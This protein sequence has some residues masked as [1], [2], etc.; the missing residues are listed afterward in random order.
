VASLDPLIVR[1]V[2]ATDDDAATAY[3]SSLVE[4]HVRPLVRTIAQR[5]LRSFTAPVQAADEVEDAVGEAVVLL[6]ERLQA[7]RGAQADPI[8]SLPDY[9]AAVAP[10]VC[11]HRVRRRHPERARLKHR[12]RYVFDTHTTLGLWR[13]SGGDAICGL[14]TWAG[15]DVDTVA[16]ERLH[17][18]G[19][20]DASRLA[21][22][23]R[24]NPAT[25]GAFAELLL[26]EL[27]G[28]IAFDDL[29]GEVARANRLDGQG[30]RDVTA[31]TVSVGPAIG[32]AAIDRRRLTERLWKEVQ[33]L[34]VRQRTALLL[35]LREP[36][37]Q[38]ALW[39]LPALGIATIRDIARVI[40][41]PPLELAALWKDLPLDDLQI[42]GRLG[43]TRQQVI[44]LRMSAR[45]RLTTRLA[46][47]EKP[48]DRANLRTVS[49]SPKGD[50]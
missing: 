46:A 21:L 28:A 3:L 45:K 43:C 36:G 15:A 37:G 35:N 50:S 5:K 41:I 24:D 31:E 14:R 12:L 42:A 26:G 47:A 25:L 7:I 39:V 19:A 1:F 9:V 38:G 48:L 32:E 10:H 30:A 27:G 11:A 16:T 20:S 44:N 34:P 33:E 17:A 23:A 22:P 40:E 4:S 18:L 2:D 49:S 29:V 6:V 13:V 8:Q